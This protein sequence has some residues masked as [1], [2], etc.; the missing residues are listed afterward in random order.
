[1]QQQ[2]TDQGGPADRDE[3]VAAMHVPPRL[4]P[5]RRSVPGLGAHPEAADGR[6]DLVG[7]Q[8][9]GIGVDGHPAVD[10]MEGDP[11]DAVTIREGIAKQGRFSVAVEPLYPKVQL[12]ANGV[13]LC[14]RDAEPEP[15]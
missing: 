2:S 12:R 15:A 9:V 7:S 3:G 8:E 4:D 14:A 10:D 11:V 1:M 6:R 5:R 13:L